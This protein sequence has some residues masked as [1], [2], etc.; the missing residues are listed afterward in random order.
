MTDFVKRFCAYFSATLTF[1]IGIKTG[2]S[3]GLSWELLVAVAFVVAVACAS[4]AW[5]EVFPRTIAASRR[6]RDGEDEGPLSLTIKL[7]M[8]RV[9]FAARDDESIAVQ[10]NRIVRRGLD[11]RCIRYRDYR[12]WRR[13]NPMVFTAIIDSENQLLGFFDVFPLT[14]EAARGL[15]DGNLDEHELTIDGIVSSDKNDS[16]HMVYIASIM[17]NPRQNVF[18]PIVAKEILLLKFA[19]FLT[20]SFPPNEERSLFAY[21][22]TPSGER[23]LR[24]AGFTNTLLSKDS[25]QRDPLYEMSPSGYK[26]LAKTFCALSTGKGTFRRTRRGV[27][28]K[29]PKTSRKSSG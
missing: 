11:K 25:K 13:K 14:D 19:E 28:E 1:V 16:A 23:L 9:R 12:E 10:A 24:N 7:A 22:H 6:F 8:D 2:F 4:I 18:S 5:T 15:I 20:N 26:E 3:I 29:K 21:A 27:R 17:V